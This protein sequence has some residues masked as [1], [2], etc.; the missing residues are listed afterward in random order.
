[1]N[2]RHTANTTALEREIDLLVYRLYNLTYEEAKVIDP[3]LSEEEFNRSRFAIP[4][5]CT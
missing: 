3:A 4:V 1:M 2:K 5:Y